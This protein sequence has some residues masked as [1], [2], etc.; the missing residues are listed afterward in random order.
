M[1]TP[2]PRH[3]PSGVTAPPSLHVDGAIIEPR[4]PN[5]L[6]LPALFRFFVGLIY[7]NVVR[8]L[9]AK[10]W[11]ARRLTQP[12]TIA[13]ACSVRKRADSRTHKQIE[14]LP[15]VVPHFSEPG[16]TAGERILSWGVVAV[17]QDEPARFSQVDIDERVGAALRASKWDDEGEQQTEGEEGGRGGDGHRGV[18]G[19]LHTLPTRERV[20]HSVS[21]A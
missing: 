18:W 20:R 2:L 14:G 6:L 7:P 9:S 5:P 11:Q 3:V 13:N 8:S 12:N 19:E 1:S 16:G 10:K 17:Q 15:L 21:R 4:H